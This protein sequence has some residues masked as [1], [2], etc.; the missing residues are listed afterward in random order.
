MI[1]K[2]YGGLPPHLLPDR[3]IHVI[4]SVLSG[5]HKAQEYYD[6]TLKPLL[7]DHHIEYS[8]HTTTSAQTVI[9]LCRS[10]IIPNATQGVKQTI[11]LLSGDGGVV[12]IVNTLTTDLNRSSDDVRRPSVFMKPVIAV[13]P[14]GTANALAWSSKVAQDALQVLFA[15]TPKPLPS[16]QATFS[17]GSKLVTDEGRGRESLAES[18]DVESVMYGAVVASWGLHASLVA[19]SD[20]A[21]YRKHGLERFRM[22]AEELL[23]NVHVYTGKIKWRNTSDE[24]EELPGS[25]HAYILTTLVSNLEEHF[26]ISPDT[27]P[28]DGSLRLLHIGP[29]PVQDILRIL[30][31]AYQAGKH[32]TDPKVTY[33]EIDALRIELD[34][35]DELWRLI[36]IDGKIVAVEKGGWVEVKWLAGS[37][38]DGRRV[39]ELVC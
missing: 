12:D 25:K 23:K 21:E 13:I 34:E 16:F 7:D 38:I 37:G 31:L 32:V 2:S 15:G 24:W 3:E 17:P 22:A 6:E 5:R 11:I 33:K 1:L 30:G 29:E 27:K 28:L 9:E 18:D 35:E 4:V 20:T 36:C 10:L 39:V 14:M 8:T 19:M 26:Q